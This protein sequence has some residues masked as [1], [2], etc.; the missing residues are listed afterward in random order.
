MLPLT[1]REP[2]QTTLTLIFCVEGSML[3]PEIPAQVLVLPLL[4]LMP[5][6]ARVLISRQTF[7]RVK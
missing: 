5:V 2:A 7:W 1:D 4:S 6:I 3:E